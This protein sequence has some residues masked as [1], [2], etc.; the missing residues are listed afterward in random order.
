VSI[1]VLWQYNFSIYAEKARWALDYK[2]VAHRRRSL[3][4]G[5]PRALAFSRRGT[6]P[7]LDLDGE[8]FGDSSEIVAELERRVPE[9]ALYPADPALRQRALELEGLLDDQTGHDLRRV[10]FTSLIEH[11]DWVRDFLTFGQPAAKSALVRLAFPLGWKFASRRYAFDPQTVERS[12]DS[13][14][15]TLDW[16]DAEREGDYLVGDAFSVADLTAAGLLYPLG[17]PPELQYDFPDAPQVERLEE[18]RAHPVAAWVREMFARHR[19]S[20]AEIT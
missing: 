1:P 17:W 7:V 20:S 16:L 18:L 6:L 3:M 19:G 5:M 15:A 9:P 8:R 10:A 12:W 14:R 13:L 4:P 11:P 2:R